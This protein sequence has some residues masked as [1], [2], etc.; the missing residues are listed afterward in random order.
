[1]D[2]SVLIVISGFPATGKTWLGKKLSEYLS[3]PIICRD[4]IKEYLFESLGYNDIDWSRKLDDAS[5]NLLYYFIDTF[6]K[7]KNNFIIESFFNP[8]NE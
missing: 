8:K 1:M 2:K 4:E 7:T 6:L 5:F 3:I